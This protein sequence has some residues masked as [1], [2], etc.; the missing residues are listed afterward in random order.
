ME[1]FLECGK[2][3][4]L[5]KISLSVEKLLDQGKIFWLWKTS[6]FQEKLT[7]LTAEKTIGLIILKTN[8]SVE[9][10]KTYLLSLEQKLKSL[11]FFEV[12]KA[13]IMLSWRIKH[14]F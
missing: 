1:S 4:L 5:W 10:I 9:N 3:P 2:F 7:F 8:T 13:N 14:N 6:L 11:A 12:D